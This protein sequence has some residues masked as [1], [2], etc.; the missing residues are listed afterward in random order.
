MARGTRERIVD[1]AVRLFNE[2][3]TGAVSTNHIA[4]ALGISPG[5]LYYHFANKEAIVRAVFARLHHAWT[6][7]AALPVDRPPTVTDLRHI[8]VAYL[9]VVWA[10]RFYYREIPVLMRRDP[11]LAALYQAERRQGLANIEAL[12]R[13]FVVAG[14]MRLP[15]D[16]AATPETAPVVPELARICWLIV[17]FWLPFE[18]LSGAPT[19]PADLHRGVDLILLVLRPYLTAPARAALEA[20]G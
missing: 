7:A 11:A 9:E 15:D 20:E 14:V 19:G 2:S 3:G 8:L 12:M 10:Y 13:Y 6:A 16:G 18:E 5:N 17:D 1:A 4:Q